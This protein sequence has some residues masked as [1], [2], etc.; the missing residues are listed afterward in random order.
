M[1]GAPASWLGQ[2][3]QIV[4]TLEKLGTSGPQGTAASE[5][6]YLPPGWRLVTAG[7]L[8]GTS[9]VTGTV[10]VV[11]GV[12]ADTVVAAWHTEQITCHPA[13]PPPTALHVAVSLE[14]WGLPWLRS[15]E[16]GLGKGPIAGTAPISSAS[17]RLRASEGG[18]VGTGPRGRA[19]W[20]TA[21]TKASPV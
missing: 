1:V 13:C 20:D 21:L 6:T 17:G 5:L 4:L 11:V 16:L 12:V 18:S 9:V 14:V 19:T 7:E 8:V 3:L 10:N 2:G 15:L